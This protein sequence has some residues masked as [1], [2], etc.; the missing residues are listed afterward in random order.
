MPRVECDFARANANDFNVRA[1]AGSP[2]FAGNLESAFAKSRAKAA[3]APPNYIRVDR[4]SH[5]RGFVNARGGS[6]ISPA[7]A[8]SRVLFARTLVEARAEKSFRCDTDDREGTARKD[9]LLR[10]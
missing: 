9:E 1:C 7:L 5:A 10:S 8:D 2:R 6:A 3:R 4:Q